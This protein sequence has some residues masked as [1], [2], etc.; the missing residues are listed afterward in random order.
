MKFKYRDN[1]EEEDEINLNNLYKNIDNLNI[2]EDEKSDLYIHI[3]DFFDD[4]EIVVINEKSIIFRDN[5]EKI[6]DD[7]ENMCQ[8][9]LE[10]KALEFENNICKVQN[11]SQLKQVNDTFD[12][13]F[14]KD[15][16]KVYEE[17]SF[18]MSYGDVGSNC[19]L[20]KEND[21]IKIK[22]FKDKVISNIF[23]TKFGLMICEDYGE[24]GGNLYN[25][26][27]HGF[28]SVG[29]DNYRYVFEYGD[30]VY[31]I[32]SLRTLFFFFLKNFLF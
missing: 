28:E 29:Y 27:E 18:S 13:L 26:T 3:E 16:E 11:F 1:L 8:K 32:A 25:F 14:Q 9:F 4:G 20:F 21:Q 15:Y 6:V 5:D 24:W 30:K 23:D 2:S 17:Y 31:A 22:T 10:K 19:Y 7:Y 12:Y